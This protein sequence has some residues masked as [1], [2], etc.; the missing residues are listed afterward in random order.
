MNIGYINAKLTRTHCG[1]AVAPIDE[2]VRAAEVLLGPYTSDEHS[3]RTLVVREPQVN[4]AYR[5]KGVFLAEQ[6]EPKEGKE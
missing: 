5:G 6:V 1:Y 4:R 2:A 3:Q